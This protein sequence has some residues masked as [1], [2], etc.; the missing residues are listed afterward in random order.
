MALLNQP[1]NNKE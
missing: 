1:L